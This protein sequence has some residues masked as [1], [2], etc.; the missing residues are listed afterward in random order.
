M[1]EKLSGMKSC[2]LFG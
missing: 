1:V 2:R